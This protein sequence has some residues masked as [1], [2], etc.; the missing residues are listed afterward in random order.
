MTTTPA[1][2]SNQQQGLTPESLTNQLFDIALTQSATKDPTEISQQVID[3]LGGALVYAL[4][5]AKRDIVLFLT[6]TL[7]NVA[8]AASPDATARA[9][10]LKQIGDTFGN[11]STAPPVAAPPAAAPPATTPGGTPP[12][13]SKP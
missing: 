11:A 2:N 10:L 3:F 8:S 7:L 12:P 1:N 6:E 13:A 9:A 5:S 4:T